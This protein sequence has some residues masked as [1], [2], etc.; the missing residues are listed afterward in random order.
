MEA[1]NHTILLGGFLIV[2][3][4]LAGMFSSRLG[5]PLLLVF[6]GLGMLAGE[7]GPGRIAFNDFALTYLVGSVALAL[8]L[9]DGA[10][11]TP[12]QSFRLAFKPAL[13]LATVGVA[14]TATVVGALAFW[15]LELSPV[16][17]FLVGAIVASTDAAAVFLL[18]NMRGTEL[19]KR[20][21]ATLEVESGINDPM[22]VFLTVA[23]VELLLHPR[24][25]LDWS[26]P[27]FFAQ[28]MGGGALIGVAG[29]YALWWLVNRAE[30]AGGLYP[31]LTAA[32]ALVVFAAAQ[33]LDCSGFLAVYL[34]GLVLGNKR[35]RAQATILRFHDGLAWL[36]QIVMFLLLGLLVTPSKLL[37]NWWAEI[38]IALGLI[39]VARPL[40]VFLCLLPAKFDWREKAFISWVGLRGAVPIFLAS[41]PVLAGVPEAMVF[42]NVAFVAVVFSLV[43]QGWTVGPAARFLGLGLPPQAEAA[44]RLEIDLPM[45]ADRDAASWR[46][47][48]QSPALDKPFK[49]LTLPRRAKVIAVIRE[50]AL[51]NRA[52]L[53]RLA[54]DDQVIALVP[55]EHTMR[56]DRLFSTRP[57]RKK[58]VDDGGEFAFAGTVKMGVL[59][60]T[61]GV[62]FEPID[63]DKTLAEFLA[64]RL[65]PDA[66]PGDRVRLGPVEL[67]INEIQ[68]GLATKVGLELE[69]PD[70]RLPVLRAWHRLRDA[71][72]GFYAGLRGRLARKR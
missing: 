12:R 20:V 23:C 58:N 37:A 51:M 3:S 8:I 21:A 7:D 36:A 55:P 66:I 19:N 15:L 31:V 40:A 65:G 60:A 18:L 4:I 26:F 25:L 56:L 42:F 9:F 53:D 24:P 30:L 72:V 5:A 29:G 49:D 50:G 52:E 10:L 14:I 59:C 47:A 6:L 17:A 32:F 28:Q 69:A 38:A 13:V 39:L 43:I 33:S 35:H 68:K 46:V 62:P 44:D 1:I 48:M 63:R 57:I 41:I 34:A 67:V 45:V 70:E 61:Y 71:G 54:V 27:L 2:A 11:R 16:A 22:A 64:M